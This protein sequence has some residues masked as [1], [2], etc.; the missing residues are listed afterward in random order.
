MASF[1]PFIFVFVTLLLAGL[2]GLVFVLKGMQGKRDKR[3]ASMGLLISIVLILAGFF[4]PT[5]FNMPPTPYVLI[6]T[7]SYDVSGAPSGSSVP[8]SGAA[9]GST[10][11]STT[12]SP[13]SAPAQDGTV[14]VTSTNTLP[15]TTSDSTPTSTT[16]S[17]GT[18]AG[19]SVQV[20]NWNPRV[21]VKAAVV[22]IKTPIDD[23]AVIT[24]SV[25]KAQDTVTTVASKNDLK[26]TTYVG[27]VATSKTVTA[28][29]G[30]PSQVTINVD[31][32]AID[33]A[34][35]ADSVEVTGSG[36]ASTP[37]TIPV[38]KVSA[39]QAGSVDSGIV[40]AQYGPNTVPVPT[41]ISSASTATPIPTFDIPFGN[42]IESSGSPKAELTVI[43]HVSFVTVHGDGGR[44]RFYTTVTLE[45]QNN[46]NANTGSI[47]LNERFPARLDIKRNP[48][49]GSS[50]PLQ[51]IEDPNG[52]I[53][54]ALF[55]FKGDGVPAHK[56]QIVTYT[57]EGKLEEG[58][59]KDYNAPVAQ[60]NSK[61]MVQVKTETKQSLDQSLL[62]LGL[63]LV[64]VGSI[65]A[66]V[67]RRKP[68]TPA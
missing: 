60:V 64:V 57:F 48:L 24:N 10:T 45:L 28:V 42:P 22:S 29:D 54:G 67:V 1:Q 63:A 34:V 66:L 31:A 52:Q 39:D 58:V 25:G 26:V 17:T 27:G 50:I 41:E 56:K 21:P 18:S 20:I 61:A 14:P 33:D 12:S 13:G 49:V 4:G 6:P 53:V 43:R 36:P 7:L 19:V 9:P 47:N 55:E 68:Q 44:D 16:T 62:A 2:V 59:L 5:L 15:V 32:V 35:G 11:T 38:T 65:I 3:D 40:P 30:A 23:S 37:T 8:A 46:G 51:A